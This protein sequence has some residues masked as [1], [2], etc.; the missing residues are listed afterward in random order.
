MWIFKVPYLQQLKSEDD[1]PENGG[2]EPPGLRPVPVSGLLG[3]GCTAGG[4]RRASERSFFCRS[5]SLPIVPHRSPSLA[6]P[7]EPAPP[8]PHP[9]GL[10]KNCLP[11]N[12]SLVPKRLGTAALDLC[13]SKVLCMSAALALPGSLVEMQT[14]GPHLYILSTS[15]HALQLFWDAKII[16]QAALIMINTVCWR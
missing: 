3:T 14:L 9:P 6:L 7:P 4:E 16:Q 5:P 8:H 13:T 10:W 11:R 2:P 12:R 15:S 1:G